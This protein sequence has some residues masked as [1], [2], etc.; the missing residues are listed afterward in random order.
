MYKIIRESDGRARFVGGIFSLFTLTV[1]WWCSIGGRSGTNTL[2]KTTRLNND[3]SSKVRNIWILFFETS[4]FSRAPTRQAADTYRFV[5]LPCCSPEK[6]FFFGQTQRS[7]RAA[8]TQI[9]STK[10]STQ[11]W[12]PRCR[13][14]GSPVRWERSLYGN[15]VEALAPAGRRLDR[16]DGRLPF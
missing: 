14:G 8:F 9:H 3:S 4:C 6:D 2:K 15:G 5:Q 12:Q 11:A 1:Y 13:R 10:A 7:R 16:H